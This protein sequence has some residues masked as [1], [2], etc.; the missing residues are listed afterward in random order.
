[1]TS[2][3]VNSDQQWIWLQGNEIDVYHIKFGGIPSGTKAIKTLSRRWRY[4]FFFHTRDVIFDQSARSISA[5]CQPLVFFFFVCFFFVFFFVFW[6]I[7]RIYCNKNKI[8]WPL[9][10]AKISH[11]TTI[12]HR[13]AH[14]WNIFQHSKRNFVS[15]RGHLT[16]SIYLVISIILTLA[17]SRFK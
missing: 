10:E 4:H 16:S 13:C 3:C 6:C 17:A 12:F 8:T 2:F 14:S 9:E 5:C 11:D 1:M 15:P 7:L